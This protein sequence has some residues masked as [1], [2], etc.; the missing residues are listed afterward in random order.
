VTTELNPTQNDNT[1]RTKPET[2]DLSQSIQE[3]MARL[4]GEVVRCTRVWGDRYRCNWWGH[5]DSD[6]Q[7]SGA[8]RI[9][10]SK[11][12]KA[13]LTPDGLI[14]EDLTN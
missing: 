3:S 4:A 10:R 8:G 2:E 14:I 12:L 9:V 6:V 11:F 5:T 1:P 13:T 7:S